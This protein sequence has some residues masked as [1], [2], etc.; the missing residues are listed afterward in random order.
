MKVSYHTL[1]KEN[2]ADFLILTVTERETNMLKSLIDPIS[3]NGI[4]EIEH[5]GRIYSLGRIGQF[6]II[7]CKCSN[8]GTQERGSSTLITRNALS[9]WPCLKGVAM[10]GIA[11]GMYDDESDGANKQHFSDVLVARKIYPYEKQK[12]KGGKKEYRGD[13]HEAN[14]TFI[15]AFEE[16]RST[17]SIQNM[18]NENVHIEV[19]PLLSGEKLFDDKIE[20]NKL[21]LT[22][23]EARGGEMEGIGLASACEDARIPWILLKGICDFGDG[24][25]EKQKHER[26][27]NAALAAATALQSVFQREDLL[28]SLCNNKKSQFYYRPNRQIEDLILF[29]DYI[30]DCEP[31]YLKRPVDDLINNTSKVKGCWV[32]GK[33][34]VGKTVALIRSLELMEVRNVFIDMATMVNQSTERMFRFV[35]EE[36]CDYFETPPNDKYQQLHDVAKGIAGLIEQNVEQNEFYIV[37]EELPLSEEHGKLFSEFVQQLCSIIISQQFKKCRVTIKFM[38]SSIASPLVAIHDIQEKVKSYIRFV[39]MVEWNSDECLELWKIIT[40]EIDYH[41][42]DLTP[43]EFVEIMEHSPRRIKDC[44]RSHSFLNNR[45]ISKASIAQL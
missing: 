39:P 4:I 43:S 24:T 30:L 25:K 2:V 9:D 11:F 12:L 21:K 38:L 19:S 36:I 27:D 42:E 26:Q 14:T 35:Y 22:F 23:T 33:S 18:Y 8:M 20:R 7:H 32:F 15:K 28:I 13:W 29:D 5:D 44:L 10:V 16:I 40:A 34:G 6:N 41:L 37:I 1:K 31:F 45:L 3:D 17:W